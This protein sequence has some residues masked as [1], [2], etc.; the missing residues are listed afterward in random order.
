MSGP[1]TENRSV[2]VNVQSLAPVPQ[3]KPASP[4]SSSKSES[5][6]WLPIITAGI[7]VTL[8]LFTLIVM[9]MAM[10]PKTVDPDKTPGRKMRKAAFWTFPIVCCLLVYGTFRYM[11]AQWFPDILRNQNVRWALLLLTVVFL[12][13]GWIWIGSEVLLEGDENHSV[14]GKRTGYTFTVLSL[15]MLIITTV[16]WWI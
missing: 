1:A 14:A 15:P 4:S 6:G 10:W 12:I 11:K 8:L 3:T 7:T 9:R 2:I 16:S 5:W 13:V